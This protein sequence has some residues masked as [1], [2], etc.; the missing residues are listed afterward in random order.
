MEDERKKDYPSV[1]SRMTCLIWVI[2]LAVILLAARVCV[3][4]FPSTGGR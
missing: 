4:L 3:L 1:Q 2:L